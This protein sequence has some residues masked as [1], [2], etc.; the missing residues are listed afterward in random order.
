MTSQDTLEGFIMQFPLLACEPPMSKPDVGSGS[1]PMQAP[2]FMP[3]PGWS[4]MYWDN[5]S[6][7]ARSCEMDTSWC[8]PDHWMGEQSEQVN[9]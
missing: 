5:L 7:A 2:D 1:C 6:Y 9:L 4:Y 8:Y 3:P